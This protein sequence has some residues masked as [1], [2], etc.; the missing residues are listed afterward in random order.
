MVSMSLFL[1]TGPC[2]ILSSK[3]PLSGIFSWLF[4][5][6]LLTMPC[7]VN[8]KILHIN[9]R[10]YATSF[11]ACIS[12][13]S[14]LLALFSLYQALGSWRILVKVVSSY[15][16]LLL[17]PVFTF[18]TF[19]RHTEGEEGLVMSWKWTAVNMLVSFCGVTL[20]M[21]FHLHNFEIESYK[22]WIS[23]PTLSHKGN[24]FYYVILCNCLTILFTTLLFFSKLECGVLL[25]SDPLCPHLLQDGAVLPLESP[26]D[27][28]LNTAKLKWIATCILVIVLIIIF[29]Y[30]WHKCFHQ[31]VQ[32][33]IP[34]TKFKALGP[35][36]Y[37]D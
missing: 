31:K 5:L 12:G 1:K 37:L 7:Q 21:I 30:A 27:P 28:G 29:V 10:D 8:M 17:L 15:P 23:D 18:F 36:E 11:F 4:L 2:F 24:I 20:R 9:H 16:A 33:L 19:G 6:L 14:L 3:G 13:L 32:Y 26:E 35:V 22:S 34:W 25:P